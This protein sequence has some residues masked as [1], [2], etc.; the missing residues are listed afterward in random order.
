MRQLL[1]WING[2]WER[3]LNDCT[4]NRAPNAGFDRTFSAGE[5]LKGLSAALQLSQVL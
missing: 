1:T 4:V 5:M 3:L 2:G